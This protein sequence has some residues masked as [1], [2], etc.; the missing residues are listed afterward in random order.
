MLQPGLQA[1]LLDRVTPRE[2]SSAMPTYA[3]A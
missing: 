3:Y 2:R 1:F